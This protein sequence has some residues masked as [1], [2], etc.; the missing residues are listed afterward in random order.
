MPLHA[1]AALGY[2]S[3]RAALTEH[4]DPSELGDRNESRSA[5]TGRAWCPH[6][7]EQTTHWLEF[8]IDARYK[9]SKMH[10]TRSCQLCG[11]RVSM[12]TRHHLIPRTRHANKRNKREFERKEVKRRIAWLCRACHDHHAL[13]G[14]SNRCSIQ[15]LENARNSL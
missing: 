15:I 9:Y 10:E 12:L 6:H 2:L 11:R 7:T 13:A 4:D 1:S 14:I 8:Q 5:P 3:G